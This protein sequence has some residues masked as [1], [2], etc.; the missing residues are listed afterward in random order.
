LNFGIKNNSRG[1]SGGYPHKGSCDNP[2]DRERYERLLILCLQEYE[3]LV[4]QP[5]AAIQAAFF[6][7][8]GHITPKVGTDAAIFNENG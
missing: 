4:N 3:L 2:Y 1:A 5:V 8:I 6:E 7:E